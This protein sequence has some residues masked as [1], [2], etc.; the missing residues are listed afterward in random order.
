MK[1]LLNKEFAQIKG[2]NS[3]CLIIGGSPLY[4]GA[5]YFSAISCF[6]SGLDLVYIMTSES[7]Q[8]EIKILL[9]ESIVLKIQ[10]CGWIL[11]RINICILGPGLGRPS[12]NEIMIINDIVNYLIQKNVYFIIDGDGINWFVNNKKFHDYSKFIITPNINEAKKLKFTLNTNWILVR[13]GAEDKL[14]QHNNKIVINEE[15]SK[16]RCCGQGDILNGII[17]ALILKNNEEDALDAI[18]YACKIL[19]KASFL[20]FEERKRGLIA[21]DIIEKLE[22]AFQYFE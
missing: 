21:S 20:A 15:S 12:E 19:R 10:K 17:A 13:K 2:C 3:T 14:S 9:P 22:L 4:T 7:A 16:R 11:D 6:R 5:P 8:S 18:A 1:N